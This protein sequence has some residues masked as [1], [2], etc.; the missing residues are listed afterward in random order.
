MDIKIVLYKEVIVPTGLYGSD[1]WVIK[2]TEKHKLKVF[3]MK[4]LRSMAGVSRV[5]S[6][7]N[8]LMRERTD[9]RKELAARVDVNVLRWF[10]HSERMDDGC[11]LKKVMNARVDGR[12]KQEEVLFAVVEELCEC[13]CET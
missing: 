13:V 8:K 9:V 5:D 6:V 10:G 1:F 7:R 2:V 11:L 4:C 12:S 3:E